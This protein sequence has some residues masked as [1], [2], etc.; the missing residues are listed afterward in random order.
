M[1]RPP[2][3]R[4]GCFLRRMRGS[5]GHKLRGEKTPT[6]NLVVGIFLGKQTAGERRPREASWTVLVGWSLLLLVLDIMLCFLI[7]VMDVGDPA[8]ERRCCS[9]INTTL[10]V[11]CTSV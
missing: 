7:P 2:S 3:S 4:W 5:D 10:V 1:A 6:S 11:S 8:V 9:A